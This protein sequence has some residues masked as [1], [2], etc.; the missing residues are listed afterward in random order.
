MKTEKT[1]SGNKLSQQPI[2]RVGVVLV[3]VL[4]SFALV[5]QI[6]VP[7]SFGQYGYYRGD[8]VSE[9]ADMEVAFA[10]ES[11]SC[12]ACHTDRFNNIKTT[13]HKGLNCQTCHGPAEK[14]A[15]DPGG[16]KPTIEAS[17]E[18]CGTCHFQVQGRPET[19]VK[20]VN[21]DHNGQVNCVQCHPAHAPWSKF[22]GG[23]K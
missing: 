8:S 14:H 6:S 16:S 4:A 17:R 22:G 10:D 7:E 20:Q 23:T 5:Q 11:T 13:T 2:F 1:K 3:L 12:A 21:L 19:A 18:F 9:W 15:K